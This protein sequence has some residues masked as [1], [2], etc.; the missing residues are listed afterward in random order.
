MRF[1]ECDDG[2]YICSS[3]SGNDYIVTDKSCSCKGFQFRRTCKH[4][5]EVEKIGLLEKMKV[6]TSTSSCV[7]GVKSPFIIKMRKEAIEEW[8]RKHNRKFTKAMI[9]K[10]EKI[11]TIETPMEECIRRIR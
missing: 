10:I 3:E 9:N 1:T 11:M 4:F 7:L 8:F 6:N 5:K 2:S